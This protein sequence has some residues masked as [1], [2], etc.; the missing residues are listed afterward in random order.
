MP[1][2]KGLPKASSSLLQPPPIPTLVWEE[3]SLDFVEGLPLSQGFNTILVVVDL[4][5]KYA[6]FIGLKHPFDAFTVATTYMKEVVPLHG[7]PASIVSDRER[8]FLST[9]WNEL[10]KTSWDGSKE[11]HRLPPTN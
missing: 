7:F 10:F 11:E 5:S 4:L 1:A 6:H 9:F 2:T 8:M 3:V